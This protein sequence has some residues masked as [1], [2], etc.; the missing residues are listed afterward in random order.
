MESIIKK[1]K[2]YKAHELSTRMRFTSLIQ[3]VVKILHLKM[4]SVCFTLARLAEMTFYR[5][6]HLLFQLRNFIVY[7]TCSF[8]VEASN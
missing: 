4:I 2:K 5:S 1:D 8:N 7:G 6:L 3:A